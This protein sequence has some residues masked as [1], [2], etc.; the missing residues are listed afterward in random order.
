MKHFLKKNT[1]RSFCATLLLALGCAQAAAQSPKAYTLFDNSGREVSYRQMIDRLADRDVV[2]FGENHNCP[3]AHWMELNVARSLYERHGDKLVIGEEMME[4]DN[5][6]ILDEYMNRQISYDRF[7]A[8]AR[9][10]DNYSTDYY[11]VVFFAKENQHSVRGHQC[12]PTLCQCGE[13]PRSGLSGHSL[14]RSQT[15]S[16]SSASAVHIR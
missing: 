16:A 13:E 9:L 7:E 5:Q 14:H 3:I 6:L 4:A 12:S 2:F 8:E 1:C 15:L 11:P 10:W